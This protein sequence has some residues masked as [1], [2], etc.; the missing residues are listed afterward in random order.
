M[1]ICFFKQNAG[2]PGL[3]S[4]VLSETGFSSSSLLDT[5]SEITVSIALHNYPASHINSLFAF[6]KIPCSL[7][8]G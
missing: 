7:L 4:G 2:N 5:E 6:A 8:Q 1:R 3:F